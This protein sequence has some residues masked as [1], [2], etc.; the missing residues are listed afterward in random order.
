V[1]PL[2]QTLGNMGLSAEKEKAAKD[3]PTPK[4]TTLLDVRFLDCTAFERNSSV[5]KPGEF[6]DNH[7][8]E[9]VRMMMKKRN[10]MN[11]NFKEKCVGEP[12]KVRK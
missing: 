4:K 12:T 1:G 11:H 10:N 8:H 7:N 6:C 2:S 5:W 3:E 9:E